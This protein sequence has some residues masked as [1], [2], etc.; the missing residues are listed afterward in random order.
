MK[1]LVPVVLLSAL[2]VTACQ[3]ATE[4]IAEQLAEQVEGVDNVEIDTDSGEIK[5]ETDD[6]SVVIGGGELPD[7][8][9]IPLP[10]GYQVT[11]VFT[12]EG[13]SA[14]SLAY[15]DADFDEIVG[16]FDEWT[17]GQTATWTKS[18]SSF[19]G[20]DGE[21]NS[22]NWFEEEGSSFITIS[23]LCIVP[24]ASIDPE[25]CVAVTINTG[26]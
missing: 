16:F 4:T 19:S 1:R 26:A 25:N 7:N 13:T 6:G 15:P 12:A 9:P 22:V 17:T 14:V 23:G 3:S 18:T 8:F 24:D 21:I 5:L 10:D 20:T 2:V 11:S